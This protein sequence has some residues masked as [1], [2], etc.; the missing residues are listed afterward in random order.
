[1]HYFS[2]ENSLVEERSAPRGGTTRPDECKI[3]I[4]DAVLVLAVLCAAVCARMVGGRKE[5]MMVGRRNP[6]VREPI[7]IL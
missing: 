7:Q 1:M 5:T 2:P 3:T 6:A 4:I